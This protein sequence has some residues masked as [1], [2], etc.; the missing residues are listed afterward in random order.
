MS[1]MPE[2]LVTEAVRDPAVARDLMGRAEMRVS[3]WLAPLAVALGIADL[4]SGGVGASDGV[5]RSSFSWP[6]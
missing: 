2:F 4:V 1:R 5:E 6:Q 3:I